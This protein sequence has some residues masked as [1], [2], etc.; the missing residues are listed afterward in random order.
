MVFDGALE[1]KDF[2]GTSKRTSENLG[3]K[4]G[5]LYNKPTLKDNMEGP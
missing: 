1:E 2:W 3:Y 4:E 5:V